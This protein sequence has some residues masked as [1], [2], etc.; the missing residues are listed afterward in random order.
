MAVR[1]SHR[2]TAVLRRT[3]DARPHIVRSLGRQRHRKSGVDEIALNTITPTTTKTTRI[4]T[5]PITRS[6]I[7]RLPVRSLERAPT[8]PGSER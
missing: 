4:R 7:T 3:E 6:Q 1:F 2:E 5:A 8:P